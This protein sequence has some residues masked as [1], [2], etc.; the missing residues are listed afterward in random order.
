MNKNCD[1]FYKKIKEYGFKLTSQRKIVLNTMLNHMDE[2]LTVEE[3]YGYV[4][5]TN[6][7][8]GLATVYRNIQMLT[9]MK[10]VDKLI[11]GDGF[12][13]Y[14]IAPNDESHQHHHLICEQC[15]AVIE[16]KEDL[17]D[18]IEQSFQ[19]IYGFLVKDHQAKFYGVCR[20]CQKK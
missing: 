11:L 19:E 18:S 20:D 4:K 14:E 10:I 16:V 12:T 7:E 3:I 15:G 6:P 2:H 9:E 8:V 5:D 17:L 1:E 13:R